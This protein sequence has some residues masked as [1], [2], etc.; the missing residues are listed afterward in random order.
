MTQSTTTPREECCDNLCHCGND[1]IGHFIGVS[2]CVTPTQREESKVIEE[3]FR[4]LDDGAECKGRY[5]Y[6]ET[7]ERH[8]IVEKSFIS[9]QINNAVEEERMRTI[10]EMIDLSDK[11]ESQYPTEFNEWRAFKGF[12][13]TLRD[14]M[15][16]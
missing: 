14:L 15:K 11:I 16:K 2:G 1:D 8:Y 12:R 9:Q 5:C 3:T 13:N 4:V 6:H 7:S 10:E